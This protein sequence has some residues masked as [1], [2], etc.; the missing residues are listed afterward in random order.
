MVRRFRDG[1][2][3]V[4]SDIKRILIKKRVYVK[5][6]GKKAR[7]Y[8][9]LNKPRGYVT[10]LKDELGRK[11]VDELVEEVGTRVYPVGR[12]DKN[13][14][15]LLIMT[16]DGEFANL[17]MHPK[18]E[19][20]KTYD[21]WVTGYHEA[22]LSLLSR[23]I[24]LDGYRIKKPAVRLIRSNGDRAVIRVTI[25]E[26]RNRQVRRMCAAAGL[27]VTRLLRVSEG[28]LSLGDLPGG[29]WRYLTA[30]EVAALKK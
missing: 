12:L 8:I 23:P 5:I 10:S 6:G 3:Y 1:I 4:L 24:E 18:H 20:E 9:A 14:E 30:A 16:N 22:S 13:S 29:S 11:T 28:A 27:T 25:H 15:G 21:V 26:G 19:V 17:L 7:V 2:F